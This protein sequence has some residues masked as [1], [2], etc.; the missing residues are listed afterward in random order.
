MYGKLFPCK[1]KSL[2][3]KISERMTVNIPMG[4]CYDV[5]QATLTIV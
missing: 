1:I 3:L 5:N 2:I 4:Y